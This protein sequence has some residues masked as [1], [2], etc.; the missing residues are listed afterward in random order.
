M[1]DGCTEGRGIAERVEMLKWFVWCRWRM[2][3]AYGGRNGKG[4][5]RSKR[6]CGPRNGSGGYRSQIS[7]NW[8]YSRTRC[9][10]RIDF[11]FLRTFSFFFF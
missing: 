11:N 4:D 9:P 7:G 3:N 2:C 6:E 1:K 5:G 8:R 10:E